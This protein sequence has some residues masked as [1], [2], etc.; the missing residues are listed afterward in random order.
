MT[1]R[2]MGMDNLAREMILCEKAGF[3]VSYGKWK[4]T[5]PPK[6]EPPKTREKG[7]LQCEYCGKLY[8]PKTKR[9]QKFCEIF[10]QQR[11]NW[12]RGKG[13]TAERVRKCREKKGVEYEEKNGCTGLLRAGCEV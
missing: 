13:R 12:E 7:W 2:R 4:A 9:P 5:Q 1:E 8:K 3:G 6:Q 11:A 10:C